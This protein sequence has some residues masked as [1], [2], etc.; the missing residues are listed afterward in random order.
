MRRSADALPLRLEVP[1]VKMTPNMPE[2]RH[3]NRSATQL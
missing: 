1:R 3:G 2:G